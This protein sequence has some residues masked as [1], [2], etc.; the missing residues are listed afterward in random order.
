MP[1]STTAAPVASGMPGIDLNRKVPYHS[2][3]CICLIAIFAQ[4]LD[5]T[6]V[7]SVRSDG[8]GVFAT[9]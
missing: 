3:L 4:P 9:D 5:E 6:D 2:I 8:I 1:F 7:A